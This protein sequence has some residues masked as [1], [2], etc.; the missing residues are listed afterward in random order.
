MLLCTNPLDSVTY[1]LLVRTEPNSA[2]GTLYPSGSSQERG[3][4]QQ[5]FEWGKFNIRN[6]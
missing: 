5:Y 4:T 3:T 1:L 6:Y 2:D